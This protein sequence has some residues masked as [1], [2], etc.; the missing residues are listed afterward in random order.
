MNFS[1]LSPRTLITLPTNPVYVGD[2]YAY[3]AEETENH[4]TPLHSHTIFLRAGDLNTAQSPTSLLTT[5]TAPAAD[6]RGRLPGYYL[7]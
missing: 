6:Y 4:I 3:T 2:F 7:C 5:A 1:V